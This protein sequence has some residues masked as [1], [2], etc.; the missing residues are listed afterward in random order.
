MSEL[1]ASQSDQL[2][3]LMMFTE[4]AVLQSGKGFPASLPVRVQGLPLFFPHD[5]PESQ[6]PLSVPRQLLVENGA[7]DL[8]EQMQL[9][10]E[11]VRLGYQPLHYMQFLEPENLLPQLN[12]EA[13]S[14]VISH[15]SEGREIEDAIEI[16]RTKDQFMTDRF[17]V[18]GPEFGDPV[19]STGF[20]AIGEHRINQLLA[21]DTFVLRM[22]ANS[23]E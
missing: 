2:E 4:L 11:G 18:E 14:F 21:L 22:W 15:C 20:D 23:S 16:R 13:V 9:T 19:K 10:E 3:N 1:S 17:R 8:A 6:T 12:L 5:R 7:A